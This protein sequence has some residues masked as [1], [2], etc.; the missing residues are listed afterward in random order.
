MPSTPLIRAS[1]MLDALYG[2]LDGYVEVR[3][4]PGKQRCFAPVGDWPKLAA[5]ARE[6]AGQN[7]YFGA[8]LRRDTSSGTLANCSA[9]PALF[10]DI[11]Y[12]DVPEADARARLAGCPL[13]PSLLVSTGG[14]LHAYWFLKEPADLRTELENTERTLGGLAQHLNAD[15]TCAEAARVLRLPNTLNHK[16]SPARRVVVETFEPDR[17][18]NLIDFE[19][20]LPDVVSMGTGT[21]DPLHVE[22]D[23]PQGQRNETLFRL[24]RS[25]RVKGLPN[26]TILASLHAVNEQQCKPPFS[27][28]E[29][30]S[31]CENLLRQRD[32]HDFQ[33]SPAPET[34]PS[35]DHQ[36][37]LHLTPASAIRV[38]PVRWLWADRLPLGSLALLGGREGVGKTLCAYMLA[39]SVTRG[40]LEGEYFG[41]PRSVIVAATED[42]WEHTIVPRLMAA[43]ADLDR[44]YRVDVVTSEG[45]ESAL[46][47]PRDLGALERVCREV[48]AALIILDPLLSRLEAALDTHKDQQVRLALEP[49]VRLADAVGVAVLGVIHVNKSVSTDV[50]TSLMASRAF[51][52]VARA[53][54][55]VMADPDDE[56]VRLLG[57]AKNNLG[58]MDLPTLTFTI[59]GVLVAT[60][61]EGEVWTGKVEWT[62]DTDRT[63]TEAVGAAAA[64]AGDRTATAEAADWLL[65]YLTSQGG[66]KDSATIKR[67]GQQAGHHAEALRRAR[68]NLHVKSDG[69]GFP[70][71]TYWALPVSRVN[72]REP[73]SR[74]SPG[75][76]HYTTNTTD[77]TEEILRDLQSRQPAPTDGSRA[78]VVSVASVVG[79]PP[80]DDATREG[81]THAD[82]GDTF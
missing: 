62:G 75:E 1:Q 15:P 46:S 36:R 76:T 11:D 53:V 9:L 60:T 26:A 32:R 25:L 20:W 41:T 33:R 65:D 19:G 59:R 27:A 56:A 66:T 80:R 8:A 18:V 7:L 55:I 78:S 58:R 10:V 39:A 31:L 71:Q 49:L 14:G 63:I 17:R 16:Y 73:S 64:S 50:L 24:G 28:R 82:D 67:E 45:V 21:R 48:E 43:G 79:E 54:L 5:F 30:A 47:L 72:P 68:Q 44:V 57:Q 70:R 35:D 52:A 29:V 74:V 40:T 77:T 2:G 34:D 42:S 69:R 3:A 23:I 22:G 38:R 6:Q 4:L 13:A 37:T 61:D 81:G 51:A 12:K